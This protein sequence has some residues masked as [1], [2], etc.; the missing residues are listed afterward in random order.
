MKQHALTHKNR[1]MKGGCSPSS[2]NPN[3]DCDQPKTP[4]ASRQSRDIDDT[5]NDNSTPSIGGGG[6]SGLS[7]LSALTLGL[8]LKRPTSSED[9]GD[10]LPMSKRLHQPGE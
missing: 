7:G 10:S 4:N 9:D 2:S 8:G 3:S 6:L 1:D 5:S